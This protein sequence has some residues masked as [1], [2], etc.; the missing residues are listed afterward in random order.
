[1]LKHIAGF[2]RA[3]LFPVQLFV[4]DPHTFNI[5]QLELG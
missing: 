4:F 1:M 5:P 2:L 3:V